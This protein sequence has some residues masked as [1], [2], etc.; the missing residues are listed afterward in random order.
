MKLL[1]IGIGSRFYNVVNNISYASKSCIKINKKSR[2]EFFTI[3]LGVKQGDNLS[4]T[5]FKIFINDFPQYL[6][7]TADPV[8]LNLCPIHCL[9]YAD[10]I[11]ILS[12]S[13]KGL[14]D[15][16]QTLK[17]FCEDW[18]LHVNLSKTKIIIFNKAGRHLKS[19]LPMM[20]HIL[21]VYQDVNI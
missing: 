6:K 8:E 11:V 14:Q 21:N 2:T 5:L 13:S 15:K 10:D 12:S 9:M 20:K 3:N 19:N 7:S 4:P 17:K 16:I 18:C 1:E